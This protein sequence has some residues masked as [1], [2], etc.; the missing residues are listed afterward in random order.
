M[1]VINIIMRMLT[2]PIHFLHWR[3][4]NFKNLNEIVL[5]PCS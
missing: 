5:L 3:S 2:T 4:I 1:T